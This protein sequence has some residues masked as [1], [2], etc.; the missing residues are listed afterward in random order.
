[1]LSRFF[2]LGIE[3]P[4][5]DIQS[6]LYEWK[7]RLSSYNKVQ[8]EGCSIKVS[9]NLY[10]PYFRGIHYYELQTLKK[11]ADEHNATGILIPLKSSF[12]LKP[13]PKFRRE[14]NFTP[15]TKKAEQKASECVLAHLKR[16]QLYLEL[17]AY[18]EY[19]RY[20]EIH[21]QA[22]NNPELQKA[23]PPEYLVDWTLEDFTKFFVEKESKE[24]GELTFKNATK[25]YIALQKMEYL[26]WSYK[27]NIEDVAGLRVPL[28][29]ITIT[30]RKEFLFD[31][32]LFVFEG[33][34]PTFYPKDK[35][36]VVS[37]FH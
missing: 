16:I 31:D 30:R 6:I 19:T 32:L 12:R 23:L 21:E 1:M 35:S 29:E 4:S 33:L 18:E 3:A 25:I 8:L 14:Y 9:K 7:D 11:I 13:I 22:K 2:D 10:D 37:V 28:F 17:K 20:R 24:I 27:V 15:D 5:I 36:L 34:T 26:G